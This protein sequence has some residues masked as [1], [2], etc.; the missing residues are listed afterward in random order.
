MPWDQCKRTAVAT[1]R[2]GSGR[3][4][5]DFAAPASHAAERPGDGAYDGQGSLAPGRVVPAPFR[6]R[7]AAAVRVSTRV[8]QENE[9]RT[10]AYV[11][12]HRHHILVVEDDADARDAFQT[13]LQYEGC[14]VTTANDGAEALAQLRHGVSPC[15]II[16][17]LLM[18]GKSGA[19]F[20]DEQVADPAIADIPV[21]LLSGSGELRNEAAR[22][23]IEHYIAKPL[24]P[25][26][27]I[28][29]VEHYCHD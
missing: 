19:D 20:R 25:D 18:P 11:N 21:V 7:A 13:L 8:A 14:D 27:L 9:E 2:R 16:L 1:Y 23:G 26:R 5:L 28:R 10:M 6:S 4:K 17:D 3:V 29:L 24:N 22:L 12:R 15:L